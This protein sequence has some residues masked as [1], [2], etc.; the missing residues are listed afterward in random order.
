MTKR[1]VTNL[2]KDPGLAEVRAEL[3][4]KLKRQ[5]VAA[6]EDAPEIAAAE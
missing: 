4:E 1:N 3:A 6:G 2:V 5:M